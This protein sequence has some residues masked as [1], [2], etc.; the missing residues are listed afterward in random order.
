[1]LRMPLT[2]TSLFTLTKD[3]H[4]RLPREVRDIIYRHLLTDLEVNQMSR[5]SNLLLND[6][7]HPR[8]NQAGIDDPRLPEYANS[9]RAYQAFAHE[10]IETLYEV[11]PDFCVDGLSELPG[12]MST[13]FFGTGWS[14]QSATLSGL[15]TKLC[16]D[17]DRFY[18]SAVI[19]SN[20]RSNLDALLRAKW[21]P[22]FNLSI[23]LH[24]KLGI[25]YWSEEDL[26]LVAKTIN[27][28]W[29]TL[30]EFIPRV[31]ARGAFVSVTLT[32]GAMM[33]EQRSFHYT[34]DG[35]NMLETEEAWL[36]IVQ[37]TYPPPPYGRGFRKRRKE[38]ANG[39]FQNG[40]QVNTFCCGLGCIVC[41]FGW[42]LFVPQMCWDSYKKR[43]DRRWMKS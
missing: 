28:T 10:V 13:D 32:I 16:L 5:C 33:E 36:N 17:T 2:P 1:M 4:T 12:F 11:Y 30:A 34:K 43:R 40:C 27:T 14:P 42:V 15:A 41:C 31:E 9:H 39:P 7:P 23:T 25:D 3:V 29:L 38:Y 18:E 22:G 8:I 35:H 6:F 24:T 26:I 20:L 37:Q 21:G 19:Q